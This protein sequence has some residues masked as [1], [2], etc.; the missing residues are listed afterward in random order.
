MRYVG[1]G[2][3]IFRGGNSYSGDWVNGVMHGKGI[4]C[5]VDGTSYEGDFD[6]NEINWSVI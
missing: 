6:K 4:Y 2:K 5:W 1:T 3:A